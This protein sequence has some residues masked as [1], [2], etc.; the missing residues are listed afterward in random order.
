MFLFSGVIIRHFE[1]TVTSLVNILLLLSY[2]N[3]FS[4]FYQRHKNK[5][6]RRYND[7]FA[8]HE[9]L[10]LKYPFRII[11]QLPPKKTVNGL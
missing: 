5:V 7:F 3:V 11:P 4:L 10:S 9:L 8:L 1:Y 6:S 2:V